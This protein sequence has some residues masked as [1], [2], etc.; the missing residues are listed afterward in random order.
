[1]PQE[2]TL[3]TE[4]YKTMMGNYKE[5]PLSDK[6]LNEIE[7]EIFPISIASSKGCIGITIKD[8]KIILRNESDEDSYYLSTVWI[9]IGKSKNII[10]IMDKEEI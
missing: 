1:M 10:E 4:I 7:G 3:Y 5:I 8:N 2:E 9:M 6:I